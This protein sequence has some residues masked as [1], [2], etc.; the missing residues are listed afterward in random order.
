MTLLSTLFPDIAILKGR[1]WFKAAGNFDFA[2]PAAAYW[3][4][5]YLVGCGGYGD[6]P[7]G[8]GAFVCHRFP[9]TP[10][11]NLK[12][13]VGNT[14][15]QSS[16]GNSSVSRNDGTIVAL[17]DRGRGNSNPG[18]AANSV[19]EVRRD[20]IAGFI[21]IGPPDNGVIF[22]GRAG[23]DRTE[24]VQM[25]GPLLGGLIAGSNS[26]DAEPLPGGGGQ[27]YYATDDEAGLVRPGHPGAWGAV[28]LEFTDLR[29]SL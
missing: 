2:V 28:C 29:P 27:I 18:L 25:F 22:G 13:Q 15:T 10:A 6:Q 21:G 16:I 19:G 5:A 14:S 4:K 17:A 12:I 9:V 3:C 7:G 26:R 11:E 24:I 23:D 8:G 20:G 1:Q